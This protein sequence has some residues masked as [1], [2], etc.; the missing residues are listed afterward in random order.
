MI[1]SFA[2]GLL[3]SWLP[4]FIIPSLGAFGAGASATFADTDYLIPGIIIGRVGEMGTVAIATLILGFLAVV[5]IL[6]AV[7]NARD[8]SKA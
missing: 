2:N 6:S 7:L 8:K 3:L 5:L 1:G 4:L